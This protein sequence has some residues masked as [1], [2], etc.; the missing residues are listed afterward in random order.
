MRNIRTGRAG[1][2]WIAA[3]AL[4]AL[5]AP[6]LLCAQDLTLVNT[7]TANGRQ[8]QTTQYITATATRTSAGDGSEVVLRLDQKKMYLIHSKQK[9]YSEMTFDEMQKMASAASSA[10]NNLPPE[11]AA[12]MQK[13]MGGMGGGQVTV[14]HVGAGEVIAGYPTEKYH[15]VI[16]AIMEGDIWA[17]PGLSLPAVFYDAMKAAT[18]STPM[19]DMKKLYEEYKKIK[20]VPLKSVSNT[21]MMGQSMTSTTLV[22]AVDKSRIPASTFEVPAG[23]KLVPMK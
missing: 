4:A 23:F 8:T 11:A 12:Q 5:F 2:T 9:T 20:G 17:A 13:M 1:R 3:L 22:T 15:V 18:P 6:A 16:G 21:K 10:M 7:T 19:L 14:T